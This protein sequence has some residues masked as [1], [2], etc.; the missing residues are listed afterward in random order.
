M[1]MIGI[2]MSKTSNCS[3][4]EMCKQFEDCERLLRHRTNQNVLQHWTNQNVLQHGT[5]QNV[6][7][8]ITNQDILHF[9]ANQDVLQY[10]PIRT[11]SNMALIRT[12]SSMVQ[13]ER[14][15][16][17]QQS[18]R[19][20]AQNQSGHFSAW[21]HAGRPVRNQP[22]VCSCQSPGNSLNWSLACYTPS[23]SRTHFIFTLQQ[24]HRPSNPLYDT[25]YVTTV[26]RQQ[27]FYQHSRF[28]SAVA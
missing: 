19:S 9:E 1:I 4:S 3:V 25:T 27:L 12:F 6:L 23:S 24:V 7:R 8:Q 15:P 26:T 5:N 13:S 16:A 2:L 18:R 22:G 17:W 21:N 20:P 11:F 10:G 28:I 14:S